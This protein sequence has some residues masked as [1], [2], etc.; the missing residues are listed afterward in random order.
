MDRKTVEAK[1][2]RL[3]TRLREI[4]HNKERPPDPKRHVWHPYRFWLPVLCTGLILAGLMIFR[5]PPATMVSGNSA[6]PSGNALDRS[7]APVLETPADQGVEADAK[8]MAPAAALPE[9][10]SL[11]SSREAVP[12]QI[13]ASNRKPASEP[14]EDLLNNDRPKK[15]ISTAQAAPAQRSRFSSTVR[16]SEI[17]SCSRVRKRQY[18]SPRTIFSLKKSP[19][20][21]VWMNVLSD[22]PPLTLI[23][24]YYVNGRRYCAVPLEIRHHRMR[25]W[26]SVTLKSRKHCGKWR[27]DVMTGSGETLDRI[28]FTVVP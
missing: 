21:V 5:E 18:V 22:K 2:Q 15:P 6:S 8:D 12:A 10:A 11:L 25:T 27:V 19:T 1:D 20:P 13:Q 23:H 3:T 4:I 14:P 28:E 7:E 9:K 16:I 17:V 24:V 26:S